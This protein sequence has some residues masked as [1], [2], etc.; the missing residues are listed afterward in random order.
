MQ[1]SD[2]S[3]IFVFCVDG[4]RTFLTNASATWEQ[5]AKLKTAVREWSKDR[6]WST[7]QES[8]VD[9]LLWR[10]EFS[11]I[12]FAGDNQVDTDTFQRLDNI[13]EYFILS[14][15]NYFLY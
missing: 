5:E 1:T 3:I 14:L 9:Y 10:A 8:I 13:F 2:A 4:A 15:D 7:V 6:S 11:Y 12:F